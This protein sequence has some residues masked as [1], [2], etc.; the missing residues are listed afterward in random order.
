MAKERTN[1]V[2]VVGTLLRIEDV[3]EGEKDGVKWIA[4]TAV[5]KSGKNEIEFKYYSSAK[6]QEGKDNSKYASYLELKNRVGERVKV[7]G[8]LSGR[9]WYNEAQGQIINFNEVNAGFFNTPKPTDVD[10][11]TFEFGGFVTKP[12]HERYNEK[13]ELIAYEMEVAQENYRGNNMQVVKFTV[14]KENREVYNAIARAYTKDTTIFINGEINYEIVSIEKTEEVAFGEPLVKVFS[15]TRKS[16]VIKAGAN[17][18]LDEGLKYSSED[19]ARLKNSYNEYIADLEKEAKNKNQAGE[20]VVKSQPAT[21][22]VQNRL[23]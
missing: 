8:D 6:T 12:I 10:T 19:I 4:G 11:A 9:V 7:N 20:S 22:S 3:R 17:P 13:E 18:I 5:V 14:D 16:F 21:S 2:Y 23:L 1:K 15:S